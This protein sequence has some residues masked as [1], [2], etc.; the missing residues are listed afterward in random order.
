MAWGGVT[1]PR[2][3]EAVTSGGTGSTGL[4][5]PSQARSVWT[6]VPDNGSSQ[7]AHNLREGGTIW[8]LRAPD[9]S[10]DVDA[11]RGPARV[12]W[13]EATVSVGTLQVKR[14]R[15]PEDDVPRPTRSAWV[16]V[17]RD[18]EALL[19]AEKGTLWEALELDEQD[20]LARGRIREWSGRSRARML[21]RLATIDWDSLGGIPEMVTLTYP[22]AFP[23]DGDTAKGHLQA[24]RKRYERQF[25]KIEGAA[26]KLEFQRRGAPHFH[27]LMYRPVGVG[28]LDWAKWLGQAWYE[29]VGSGDPRHLAAGVGV[30]NQTYR[31]AG[32]KSNARRIAWYFAKHAAPGLDDGGSKA[33]QNEVPAGFRGPGRFWGV[34]GSVSTEQ[35]IALDPADAHDLARLIRSYRKSQAGKRRTKATL[36]TWSL[37][38]RPVVILAQW[39][40]ARRVEGP[41][42]VHWSGSGEVRS[43]PPGRVRPI[44]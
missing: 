18:A 5:A 25:G 42:F 41:R 1:L 23:C 6:V 10:Y 15:L 24:L 27:L 38:D 44:P 7:K 17:K 11:V 43:W 8:G 26:W 3:G 21:Y 2:P 39:L 36:R 30:D 40:A 13:W 37:V 35:T 20:R 22:R 4:T 12:P 9:T 28:W 33:Y 16:G 29:V 32:K 34:W 19:E 14:C 31:R